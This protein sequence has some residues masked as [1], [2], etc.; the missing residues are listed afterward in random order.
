[1]RVGIVDYGMGNLLSVRSAFEALGADVAIC[2]APAEVEAAERI[3]LPGV[4][5]FGEC[6]RSLASQGLDGAL[7]QAVRERAKPFLGICL[8]M[9]ALAR[10]SEEAEDGPGLG[11]VEGDVVRLDDDAG[12]LRIPHMGWNEVRHRADSPMFSGVPDGTDL[13]FVHSYAVR[14]D[15]DT[16]VEAT[17]TYGAPVTAALRAGCVWG[18]QFHPEKSQRHGLRILRNFLD[19][20][21]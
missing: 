15:R 2:R 17:T 4:G 19:W 1:L 10:K 14:L 7:R 9:Q 20:R 3:V 5:A 6:M 12:R 21:A 18:T 13:Y 11:L 16:Q 8:G